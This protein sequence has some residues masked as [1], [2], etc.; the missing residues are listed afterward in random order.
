MGH[1]FASYRTG[2]EGLD[3]A[4]A[5]E[6]VVMNDSAV[7]PLV[8]LEKMF[9]DVDRR[10]DFWGITQGYAFRPHLQSYFVVYRG[11]ALRSGAFSR[12]W[13]GVEA[14]DREAV[15]MQYEV[16]LST[17]LLEAGL[18]MATYFQPSLLERVQ[19]AIRA[20]GDD[21][22][23]Y[24]RERSPRKLVGWARRT[25]QHTREPEWNVS[26]ALADRALGRHPRLP[27]VKLSVLRDDPYHLDTEHLLTACERRHPEAFA[28]VRDYLR[29]TR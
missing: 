13:G 2:I 25:L 14:L 1:D 18:V 24:W 23:Q 20:D 21:G 29:R 26:A 15:I 4:R 5:D 16:G 6:L 9:R 3:L 11:S 12:F 7:F 17:A 27:M 10:A 19:G 28:G 22:G 8:P